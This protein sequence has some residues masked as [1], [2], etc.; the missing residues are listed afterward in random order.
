MAG[1]TAGRG[2]EE[3]G[4]TGAVRAD[5]DVGRRKALHLFRE[6][7]AGQGEDF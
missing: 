6:G 3:V 1:L 4:E 5:D 2:E 7:D